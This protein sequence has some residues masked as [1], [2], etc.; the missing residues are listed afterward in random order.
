[1]LAAA[2]STAVRTASVPAGAITPT[3]AA[4]PARG[5]SAG[6]VAAGV[7]ATTAGIRSGSLPLGAAGG[8]LGVEPVLVLLVPLRDPPGRERGLAGGGLEGR[9]RGWVGGRGRSGVAAVPL[10]RLRAVAA[11][12]LL[13]RGGVL[14]RGVV[15]ETVST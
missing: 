13:L 10:L 1:M 14:L 15:C 3:I 11:P 9:A 8:L 2:I 7:A 4:V 6:P 5:L 12:V